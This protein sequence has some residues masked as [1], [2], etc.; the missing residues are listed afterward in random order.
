MLPPMSP[1]QPGAG[2]QPAK[3][4]DR[5]IRVK[6][7][8]DMRRLGLVLGRTLAIGDVIALSGPLG[9][10]KTTLVQGLAE[11]LGVPAWRHV[12]SPTFSL[13]NQH[14]GRIDFVHVDFFRIRN[15]AELHELGLQ[16][17]FDNAATAIEWA[18]RFPDQLPED[19]LQ[20][21]LALAPREQRIVHVECRGSRS[22]AL[23]AALL[24]NWPSS[25]D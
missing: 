9:A 11:G 21:T 18:D 17:T 24:A 1:N 22:E 15:P 23:A 8:A 16:E 10:G 13:V 3:V 20:L 2:T 7:A 12:A 14:V 25:G 4:A 19:V 6:S 5:R